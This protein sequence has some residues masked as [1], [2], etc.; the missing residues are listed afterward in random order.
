MPGGVGGEGPQGSPL[1]R[2]AS[3][4]PPLLAALHRLMPRLG[5]G[6]DPVAADLLKYADHI[7]AL[8]APSRKR[9]AIHRRALAEYRAILKRLSRSPRCCAGHPPRSTLTSPLR[10][11]RIMPKY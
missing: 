2:L 3:P 6:R 1:S 5:E 9:S 8:L 10:C 4:A 7:V 11:S